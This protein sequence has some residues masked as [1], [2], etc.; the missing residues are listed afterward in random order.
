MPMNKHIVII[1]QLIP[2][3]ISMVL[4][5]AHF[6]RSGNLI[7]VAV[8]LLMLFGLFIRHPLSARL[9]QSALF[10]ST[11]EWVR[12]VFVLISIRSNAGLSWT[13]LSWILGAVAFVSFASIFVFY[14]K[15]LKDRYR[16]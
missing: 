1:C 4:I 7:F 6:L 5:G 16:L 2:V 9:M 11:A 14:S 8:S 12:T 3:I 15:T 13:R 10:L